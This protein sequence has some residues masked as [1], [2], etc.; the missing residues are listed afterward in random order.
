MNPNNKRFIQTLTSVYLISF[1]LNFLWESLHSYSL[2]AAHNLVAAQY[3]PIMLY[4]AVMDAILILGVYALVGLW[5]KTALWV[6]EPSRDEIIVFSVIAV[7]F[8]IGIEV[9]AFM[10]DRWMYLDAMPTLFGLGISPLF[11]L[12][13]TGLVSIYLT[14]LILKG[15]NA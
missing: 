9:R 13:I 12:L 11:Q 8:A 2:Y 4:V 15:S 14:K 7:I 1:L 3:V 6:E 10:F 5:K